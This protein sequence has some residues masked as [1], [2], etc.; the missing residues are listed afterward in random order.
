MINL[1]RRIEGMGRGGRRPEQNTSSSSF[2]VGQVRRS[3][4][5]ELPIIEELEDE[6]GSEE[7]SESNHISGSSE[8]TRLARILDSQSRQRSNAMYLR[9][10]PP[11]R[12]PGLANEVRSS[13]M[14]N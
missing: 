12:N 7:S 9:V 13:A 3:I 4:Q 6:N 10:P 14:V 11:P 2:N 5:A 8:A 1:N